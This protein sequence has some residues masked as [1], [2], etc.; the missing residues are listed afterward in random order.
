MTA[1]PSRPLI[2]K[3][4]ERG[5]AM[6][7]T[8]LVL[9]LMS[10]L[11][12][13]FTT[14]V[15]S[16]QRYRFID[17]D[18]GQAFYAASAGVEKLTADIGNLFLEYVAPTATQVQNLTTTPPSITGITFA[19]PQ[20]AA[21]LP[22]SQLT[23]YHCV[24]RDPVTNAIT[25]TK[26]PT[27][28]GSNGYTITFC[29]LNA[30]GNPTISDDNLVISGTGAYAGMT[31]LQSPYQLDVTAKTATGG[32]V[33][34]VRTMQSVAIPVFQFGIFSES[35]LSFF[36]EQNFSFGG[37]IH[38]NGNLWLGQ[39]A[40]TTLTTTGKITAVGDVVRQYMSNGASSSGMGLTGTVSLATSVLSPTGNRV[41]ALTEGSV[42]GLPG[43]PATTAP[44]N[45][46]SLSTGTAY[47]N[48]F[49]KTTATG[50]KRLSLPLTA[51]GIGG[52]NVDLIR[53]P[54]IGGAPAPCTGTA[55]D[56]TSILYNERLFTKASLRII[57]SDTAADISNIPGVTATPPV[58]LDGNWNTAAPSNGGAVVWGGV[59]AASG[60]PPIATSVG[61]APAMT[62]N[63][64][65]AVANPQTIGLT[66]AV[67]ANFAIAPLTVGNIP[68]QQAGV[69]CTGRT[70]TTFTG[71]T[72]A[73]NPSILL[74]AP[75]TAVVNG[76]TVS[77]TLAANWLVGATT[78]TVPAG[79]TAPFANG[80]LWLKPTAVAQS[81][82]VPA[83]G[84]PILVS[85]SGL[86]TANPYFQNCVG[87]TAAAPNG[88][89]V[90][91]SALS[92]AGTGTIGG[93][94][95]IEKSN[96]AVP[97]VWTDVTMEILNYGFGG[98]N[99]S[100]QICNGGVEVSPN[101]IIRLQRLRDNPGGTPTTAG[102]GC[103]YSSDAG[104]W[105]NPA[106]WWPNVLFDT[107]EAALRDD[108][109][110]NNQTGLPL[111]G[112]MYYVTLDAKNL[113]K[114]FNA[115]APYA[116]GTGGGSRTDNGGYTVYFSDRRNNRNAAS[117]ETGEFG[118][119][120]FIN[121]GV[122]N[123]VPNGVCNLPAEDVNG[124]G[125]CETYGG[126]PNYNGA[127]NTAV[128]GA[129]A[130]LT[131]AATPTT[132]VFRG[133][134]QVNRPIIFRR[135]LKLVNGATLGSDATVANRISGLTVVSENPVY[136]QG[137]WNASA[138]DFPPGT[139]TLHA[140]TAVI[141][142]AVTLLSNQWNDNFSFVGPYTYATGGRQ[143]LA[144]SY[145]RIA[146]L[147]GKGINFQSP[148]D[149]AA[150]SV[151]GTDGGPHNFLR[152]LEQ[153][154]G[155]AT[156]TVNYRG[157]M[158]SLYYNR[159]AVGTFKCCSGSASDG[160]VYSVPVRNFFFD[161]DFL[162]PALLPPNTPMFRDL[163]VIGFSQEL[164]PGK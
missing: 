43:S 65:V 10:A 15:M 36:A 38:T 41:M 39:F 114:W 75:V 156:N 155:A 27:V 13:G 126:I 71:C 60:R 53:R 157:S 153:D 112:M 85:C 21:A 32:E 92:T 136:I 113:A 120:D 132:L 140:A 163:N 14:V 8:L 76:Q 81:G 31:A 123:G 6:I 1:M 23:A 73:T 54:C 145:Y 2:R 94:I 149:I 62:T 115:V 158:A 69:I 95:K 35:D 52:T 133:Q 77:T 34:L 46:Q 78:I 61:S 11:L 125:T 102:G 147:A 63:A 104:G 107:R 106:N 130:P 116:A 57:L 72:A 12:V 25:N 49:I 45:W 90:T 154:G 98:L 111:G 162:Q 16:D 161:T 100:G 142:D 44:V 26:T 152:M 151:F 48:G 37:R 17:R 64:A 68:T 121:P 59:S 24:G 127:Y 148:S 117:K 128:P 139:A 131:T 99:L 87:V 96:N 84:S 7:T 137:D 103:F 30:T 33:H 91:T 82:T 150:G 141:A 159:Q 5:I 80:V 124:N 138:A 146:V 134:A 47:Y 9:M 118:W 143:R 86:Q 89:A 22:A 160:I 108:D 74:G 88:T 66:A 119:E 51:T 164:R 144:Q 58:L 110:N 93:Y 50:A 18:R 79:G 3:S 122:A 105:R 83:I 42:T 135:A 97:P 20:A 4:D 55:E 109:P 19:A 40:S 101:A 29:K 70:L 28:V 129:A 67:P 56:V